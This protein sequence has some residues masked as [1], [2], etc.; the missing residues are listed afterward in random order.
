MLLFDW[1]EGN[2]SHIALHLVTVREAEEVLNGNLSEIDYEDVD[3]EARVKEVGI[4]DAGRILFIVATIRLGRV[5]LAIAYNAPK[6]LK[7]DFLQFQHTY[8]E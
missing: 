3:G 2:R 8:Y 4:T 1:D 7:A 5:R 6:A